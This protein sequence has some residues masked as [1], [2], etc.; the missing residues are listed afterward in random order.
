MSDKYNSEIDDFLNE[1]DKIADGFEKRLDR[2]E[3]NVTMPVQDKTVNAKPVNDDMTKAKSNDNRTKTT[4]KKKRKYRLNIK[5]FLLTMLIF[6]AIVFFGV[7]G[8]AATVIAGTPAIDA[9]N[10]YSM[11]AENSILYDDKGDEIESIY[12]GGTGT[13]LRTNLDYTQMPQDLINAFIAIEDKTFRTHSGFNVIRIFGAIFEGIVTGD[14]IS[15]TST[16]TQQLARN[17]YIEDKSHRSMKRK[18]KE[19]YYAVQLERQLSKEQ[20]IE[21]YLNTIYLGSGVYGVQAASQA[22]FSKDV[23]DLTVAECAVI[24][25][26]PKSPLRYSPIK[27]LNNEDIEDP[28]SLDFIYRGDSFSIWYQPEFIP[29]QKLVLKFMKEQD[30]ITGEQYD[31]ALAENIRDSIN[32]NINAASDISSYFADYVI[33]Q[34]TEGLM[35]E[36][37]IDEDAA[38]NIIYNGGLRIHSTL[39]VN[40]QKII[41]KEFKNN[42]NFPNVSRLK[43]DKSG[44]VLDS[45]SRI[46]LYHKP[47][48]IDKNGDFIL[49][50]EEYRI[51]EKGNLVLLSGF[52][53][54]FYRTEAQGKT[55]YKIEFKS[56][57]EVSDSIFYSIP[58]GYLLI[59]AEYKTK[60]GKG[61][62]I[63]DKEY[64]SENIDK[65]PDPKFGK[66][67]YQLREKV[68]QPQ[69][70]MVVLDYKTGGIKAM[71]G[72]RSLTGKLLFNRA[73]ATRQPGSAIKPMAVYGPALQ[74]SV[75]MVQ[76]DSDAAG[77]KLWTAAS[78]ID[79]SP[80]VVQGKLWP[81]NWYPG[82]RGLT[83]LRRSVEQSINVNAVKVFTD[84]GP[85]ASLSF[86][87]KIGVTSVVE[88]GNV[89]DM[90]AAALALGGMTKGISPLQMAAAY[91]TFPNRGMYT[92]PISFTKVTDKRG[93]VLLEGA[94]D[95]RQVMD[96]G[97]AFIMTDILRT[98]VT[99]GIAGAASIGSHPVAGKTGTTSDNYDAWFV[100]TTPYY[101]AALWIGNDINLELS[102][103]SVSAARLWS[104][105]MK[106]IHSGLSASS[107]P[108]AENV[109]SVAI[110][111]KSGK[112]PSELSSLDPR[113]TVRNEYFVTGTS[114][115]EIDDIH[116]SAP[117]CGESGYLAT[118]YC[119]NQQNK[120]MIKRP[121]GSVTSYGNATVGDIEYEIPN[122][123]C[124]LHNLDPAGYPI[125]PDEKLSVNGNW[126]E[127]KEEEGDD[128]IDV[129]D[130]E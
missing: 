116:V 114:P 87:K 23:E 66:G 72:G 76:N 73:T 30:K 24:A 47:N 82:Y 113:N 67:H 86:L 102:S 9:G 22:Y 127:E 59:P 129:P 40:M 48:I 19:A 70:A 77:M 41:E 54:N 119:P 79:D 101:S 45:A 124:H 16:I 80:N 63:I 71:A 74:R 104:R 62:L 49:S 46:L 7:A 32:P 96:Q 28:G 57:Y 128:V 120:V 50:S 35:S 122:Y 12:S 20:I 51:D 8:W 55:D 43:K 88:S 56:M 14:S 53:L 31:E 81:K 6:A 130:D 83:T 15:G 37:N 91:G 42:N 85:A 89:N 1:F 2:H 109:I 21:A 69:S 118:P 25:S 106:Q 65:T 123:Y 3:G 10:L 112:L 58:G 98:T 111:T 93:D 60:D 5:R 18:L 99:S 44:N 75:E 68:V 36:Y 108:T 33:K 92:E 84:I 17:L 34:V 29:R 26:I 4:G 115:V 95:K 90:N 64:F 61:N 125:S 38:K 39:N 78:I 107:F 94:P 117:I 11:L 105:I 110:D 100:G 52:R 121:P 27:R 13:G 97:A 103:G 126:D